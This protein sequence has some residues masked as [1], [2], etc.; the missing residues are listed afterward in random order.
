M[1]RLLIQMT[2]LAAVFGC[3]YSFAAVSDINFEKLDGI[4]RA[5]DVKKNMADLEPLA[6]EWSHEWKHAVPK[7]QAIDLAKKTVQMIDDM[8]KDK[9]DLS[10]LLILKG[11]AA[12]YAYNL[13]LRE[14]T[15]IAEKSFKAAQALAPED[16]R[17]LWFLGKHLTQS[18]RSGAGVQA[19]HEV[20][21]KNKSEDLPPRFFE[22]YAF[23]AYMAAMPSSALMGIKFSERKTPSS[24]PIVK[25]LKDTLESK[26]M[27]PSKTQAYDY[28]TV[29][30]AETITDGVRFTNRMF[31]FY[32]TIPGNWQIGFG[33]VKNGKCGVNLELPGKKGASP[34]IRIAAEI[35]DDKLS[36]E[37]FV[38]KH[39][40]AEFNFQPLLNE[41]K[42]P[43]AS[44]FE[45][46]YSKKRQKAYALAIGLIRH[47]PEYPGIALEHPSEL[48]LNKQGDP[49]FFTA[50]KF[51]ARFKRPIAYM[52]MLDAPESVY[53][54]AKKELDAFLSG[55]LAE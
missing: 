44:V 13:D 43:G 39:L 4:S 50:R 54:A 9:P 42:L 41:F 1:K 11:I 29:W 55:F 2:V 17:P 10:E 15:A 23:C 21:K 47:E 34:G 51:F 8:I 30:S 40:A 16:I 45:G 7:E 46:K 32:F 31:G 6:H 48:P 18:A 28:K 3:S 20:F 5:D 27:I 12:A 25:T 22:D 19:I 35:V 37:D 53:P 24:N 38:R 26:M 52:I 49:Q 36:P 33:N 14:Y